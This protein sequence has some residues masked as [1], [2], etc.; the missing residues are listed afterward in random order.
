MS[1]LETT[2]HVCIIAY[3]IIYGDYYTIQNYGKKENLF[4]VKFICSKGDY[5]QFNLKKNLAMINYVCVIVLISKFY[6]L[7]I[8]YK[9]NDISQRRMNKL[10]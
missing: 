4:I 10:M 6:G 8:L 7:K 9:P 2:Q 5:L 1:L 3:M